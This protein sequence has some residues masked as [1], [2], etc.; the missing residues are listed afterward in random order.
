MF[1]ALKIKSRENACS[2]YGDKK[3]PKI[4]QGMQEKKTRSLELAREMAA[5]VD[6]VDI[7]NQMFGVPKSGFKR[8]R[9]NE[10]DE[11]QLYETGPKEIQFGIKLLKK[12]IPSAK[13][14]IIEC[15]AGT[16][17]VMIN[18]LKDHG[19][20]VIALANT[21]KM[22]LFSSATSILNTFLQT[23]MSF[24]RPTPHSKTKQFFST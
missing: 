21:P 4:E 10:E 20:N 2:I 6:H 12:Q 11:Q 22:I 14:I 1:Q 23:L 7:A 3:V 18:A 8:P 5:F 17:G 24:L 15:C 13:N 19:Y 16:T 9:D